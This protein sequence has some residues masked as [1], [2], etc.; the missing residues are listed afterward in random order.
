MKN[1]NELKIVYINSGPR[2][3]LNVISDKG[4][5]RR[6]YF[7]NVPQTVLWIMNSKCQFQ[8]AILSL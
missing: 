5:V 1:K 6:L 3:K 4:M 2:V 8:T 7:T